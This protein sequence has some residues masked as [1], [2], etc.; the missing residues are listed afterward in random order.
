[1]LDFDSNNLG[2]KHPSWRA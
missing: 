1:M 2:A